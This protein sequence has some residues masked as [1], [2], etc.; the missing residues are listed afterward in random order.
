M[1]AATIIDGGSTDNTVTFDGTEGTGSVLKG[2]IITGGSGVYCWL[3]ILFGQRENGVCGPVSLKD[4]AE[5]TKQSHLIQNRLLIN[6]RSISLL[7][8]LIVPH[9][10][11]RIAPRRPSILR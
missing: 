8:R 6:K 1:V 5:I 2:M 9:Y 7:N 11:S 10:S 4:S 3:A